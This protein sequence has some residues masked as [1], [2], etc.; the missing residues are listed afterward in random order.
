MIEIVGLVAKHGEPK[1]V[2]IAE[3]LIPWLKEKG[4]QVLIEA[5]FKG[6]GAKSASKETMA[7]KA[8]LIVVLGGDGTLLSIARLVE[9]PQVPILG[10]NLG[11]LGFITEV[12]PD[13]L[14]AV[15]DN[16]LAGR[17]SVWKR[18][19]LE[20]RVYSKN[21]KPKRFRVLNDAVITKGARSKIISLETYVEKE[22]LS[23]YRADGL[24]ISTPTG[25]TAYS[26]AAGGPILY[27]SL[28]AIV[29]SPICP[30]ML[31]NRPIV[32]SSKS[33][34]SV[35]VRAAEDTVFL[36]PDG[37]QALLLNDGDVVEARDY[38]VPVSLVK[39]PSRGYFEILRT[40]LRWGER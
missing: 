1:A 21:A 24:I 16:T 25:S 8:D 30:H 38:G 31:T 12:A 36:S 19:T 13:E 35:T 33:T 15:I 28:G 3:W 40:R 18:M 20:L 2:E 22:Y 11:G 27:P 29:L 6:P 14:A 37:Q 32:I 10:V 7:K 4:K 34:V 17:F 9:R 26:L 5:G 39:A 23:T